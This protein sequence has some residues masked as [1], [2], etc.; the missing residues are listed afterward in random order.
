METFYGISCFVFLCIVILYCGYRIGV[1]KAEEYKLYSLQ[2]KA[3]DGSTEYFK[4][5]N[6]DGL[7]RMNHIVQD[8]GFIPKGIQI[9]LD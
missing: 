5:S 4:V 7:T 9:I 3:T 8:D 2:I 6:T 1:R